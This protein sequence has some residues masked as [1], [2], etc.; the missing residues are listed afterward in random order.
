MN[1]TTKGQEFFQV[2]GNVDP[3]S[4]S[5][6]LRDADDELFELVKR[7]EYCNVL[8]ARQMGKS[9]LIVRTRNRLQEKDQNVHSAFIDLNIIG[10]QQVTADQWYF[11]LL[12]EIRKQ[13]N[14]AVDEKAWWAARQKLGPIQRFT[15]FL[16]EIVLQQ[17]SGQVVIFID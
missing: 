15:G 13:L 17:I 12:G 6:I 11:S 2:G 8:T 3:D 7:G 10:A 4:P 1:N 9:S 5:Y 14:L 16:R